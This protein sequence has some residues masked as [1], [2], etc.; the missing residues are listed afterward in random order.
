MD[1]WLDCCLG[2]GREGSKRTGRTMSGKSGGLA[3]EPDP[4]EMI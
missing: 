2:V 1:E 3:E 4:G